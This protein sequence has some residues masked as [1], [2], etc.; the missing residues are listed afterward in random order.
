MSHESAVKVA[1]STVDDIVGMRR[2]AR[3]FA[4]RMG[5]GLADQTRLA[6]AVSELARNV[7]QYAGEGQGEMNDLSTLA[8]LVMRVQITDKG[9]GIEDIDQVMVE[10]Y[11]SG[12]GLGAGLPG[13]LRLSDHFQIESEPGLGTCVVMEIHADR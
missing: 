6:T 11:T 10:G 2:S 9:P 12:N 13:C 8:R 5:F 1:L 7:I 4:K 3:D